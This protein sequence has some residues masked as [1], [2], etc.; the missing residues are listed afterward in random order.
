MGFTFGLYEQEVN[1]FC[2]SGTK[3]GRF[4]VAF[5]TNLRKILQILSYKPLDG[6]EPGIVTVTV[7]SEHIRNI[8]CLN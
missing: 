1:R 5:S 3:Q 4:L 7:F 2:R 6:M 8:N